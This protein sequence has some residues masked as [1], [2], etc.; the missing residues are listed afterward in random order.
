M[1]VCVCVGGG[2]P[3][4]ALLEGFHQR[5]MCVGTFVRPLQVGNVLDARTLAHVRAEVQSL[6]ALGLLEGEGRGC[7]MTEKR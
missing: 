4:G 5:R 2:S 1:C 6:V 3:W 7:H